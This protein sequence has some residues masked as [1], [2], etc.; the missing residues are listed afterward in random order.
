MPVRI[1]L[2]PLLLALVVSGPAQNLRDFHPRFESFSLPGEI[3]G[4]YVQCIAQDSLGLL[5]FATQDGL[6]RY[7]GRSLTTVYHDPLQ[8]NS[9]IGNSVQW[10]CV[11]N[12]GMLWLADYGKGLTRYDQSS[13][14]HYRYKH[15]P[16]DPNSL[17]SDTVSMVVQDRAGFVWVG[18]HRGLNRLDPKTGKVKR[19]FSDPANPHSLS[20]NLVRALYVDRQGTLWVGCGFPW[21]ETDPT[22]KTG[23]LN[24]YHP[25][26]ETF[27][28][29]L[30]DPADPNSLADNRVRALFEDSRGNF[31]VGTIGSH[32][33]QHLDRKTGR[34]ERLPPAPDKLGTPFL[35]D[36]V[37]APQTFQQVLSILEDRNGWLWIGSMSGLEIY[38]PATGIVRHFEMSKQPGSIPI[39]F[40]WNLCLAR[41]GTVW[42]GGGI[43]GGMALKISAKTQLFTL[44]ET[45][46]LLAYIRT[47]HEDAQG[48]IWL[49]GDDPT[50]NRLVRVDRKTGQK[51]LVVFE[52]EARTTGGGGNIFTI[53]PDP[54]GDLW[55]CTGNGLYRFNPKT[56]TTVQR[57]RHDPNDPNSLATSFV[58]NILK[59]RRGYYWVTT[60]GGGLNCL[61][62]KTGKFKRFLHH[63]ATPRSISGNQTIGLY[64]DNQGHIWVGGGVQPGDDVALQ[65]MFL[66]RLD[67]NTGQ[68]T[69]FFSKDERGCAGTI[70]GDGEGNIWAL[71]LIQGLIKLNPAT[72]QMK[73]YTSANSGI[74]T[75]YVRSLVRA[76]N[77]KMWMTTDH[78]LVEFDPKSEF[79]YTYDIFRGIKTC[80]LAFL[81]IH[82]AQNG[83]ILF[84]GNGGFITFF[85]KNT[86]QAGIGTGPD[87]QI[88][89]FKLANEPILP[90]PGSILQQ[91]IWETSEIR[92]AHD[93]NVFAFN[94]AC[95]DYQNPEGNH[96]EFM[97]ENYDKNWRNDLRDG[98]IAYFNVPPGEYTF[99]VRG[100]NGLGIWN[101]TGTSILVTVSPPWWQTL[102]AYLVY[103]AL[104]GGIAYGVYRFLL[105][106]RLARAEAERL[107]ELDTVKTRLYTNITHEFRT[108]LTVISGMADQIRENPT[109]WLDEGTKMIQ[110]NSNRLL[111][112]V[113]QMLDLA[114]LEGG[115]MALHIQ[116]GDVVGYLKYLVESFHSFAQ[117]RGVQIHFL[118]DAETLE[119]GFDP[120]RLQQVVGNL[121]SNAVKFT[122]SGGHVYVDLRLTT[123]QPT[124]RLPLGQQHLVVR[125]RDTGTGIPEEHLPYIFD[126]FYQAPAVHSGSE[127]GSA[128]SSYRA[129]GGTG[130]GLA[131][132][133]E[134][135]K[136]MGGDIAAKSQSGKGAEFIVT[137]PIPVAEPQSNS[138]RLE[139]EPDYPAFSF[140]NQ[141]ET[142]ASATSPPLPANRP[143]PIH[144]PLILLAEDNPDVVTYLASCLAGEYRLA[145]AKDGQEAI[146]IASETVPDLLVTDVMMP[147]KDGFEVCRTLRTDTRTSHI[148][149]VMLTAKA[150]MD[151]KLEGLEHGADVY[152]AKPF[153]KEELRLRIRKLLEMRKNLQQHYLAAAGLAE[154]AVL[155]RDLP[156]I[157]GE[158]D[159]FVRKVREIVDAHLDDSN[160]DVEQL[161]RAMAMSHSQLHRKLSALTGLSATKF[162]RHIRLSKAKEM[163]RDSN[164]TIAAV[165]YDTGFT[166]PSYFGRVFRQELGLSPQ[167]WRERVYQN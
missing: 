152:L 24:R 131:L 151:S 22:G 148:P 87:I 101:E 105:N 27:T 13:G 39:N 116:Q 127:I 134:L 160:F 49:G 90:A 91:P 120:E 166:D 8:D 99:R 113:N 167:E 10:I 78:K 106:R 26:S 55:L 52:K 9:L 138:Q 35:R 149:I 150:D 104:A 144:A 7:D 77:G 6:Q 94:L 75:N 69:H 115:K 48:N 28:R 64:Q 142:A 159:R 58:T 129:E 34:F 123:D 121:I 162:V 29:Y 46:N 37:F 19:F 51:T 117:S 81:S 130:I 83:E 163:L 44:H 14:L 32:G 53:W 97:L 45:G 11:G 122:P 25:D 38:D 154:G 60:W 80:E 164:L 95:F 85:P 111:D 47:V 31:W 3:M 146:E 76:R 33:L 109:A 20:A 118:S 98:E 92:L 41:D 124:K 145:V 110:R 119:M 66:D 5:W 100:T 71:T 108:P 79:F 140:E 18:T 16:N 161:C 157:P 165:A 72:G 93:Q 135:V 40:L 50:P 107:L 96:I 57:Y 102:W 61:D 132:T 153:N 158:E 156:A 112:L 128:D 56:N 36:K 141:T 139:S 1:T 54:D 62:P 65:P 82:V 137:L 59:D 63:P 147:R 114:K 126:R 133:R 73:K 68:F 42:A 136:L 30:H 23:G 125:V 15:D 155:P 70:T 67:P 43:T 89:G 2:L 4:N 143:A 74:P 21:D 88:V 84:G 12:D 86:A 17:S 103:L